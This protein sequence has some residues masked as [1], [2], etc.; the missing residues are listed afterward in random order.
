MNSILQDES[1]ETPETLFQLLE[2]STIQK[3]FAKWEIIPDDVSKCGVNPVHPTGLDQ[4]VV[5]FCIL[6]SGIAF[7]FSCFVAER[8]H[9]FSKMKK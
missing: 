5:L 1:P 2:Q 3:V 4:T 9:H 6:A 7:A 8:V